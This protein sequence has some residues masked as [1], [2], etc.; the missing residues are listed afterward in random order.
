ML[1]KG[2]SNA[3]LVIDESLVARKTIC[4]NLEYYKYKALE[5]GDGMEALKLFREKQSDIGL[6]IIDPKM[7][8]YSAEDVLSQLR[9]LDSAVRVIAI[10]EN[11]DGLDQKGYRD[12]V[13]KPVRTDR[14]LAVVKKGLED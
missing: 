1:Y 4:R 14:L 3:I 5:A 11:T 2:F 7:S 6:V 8:K 9:E 12:V 13:R 10:T